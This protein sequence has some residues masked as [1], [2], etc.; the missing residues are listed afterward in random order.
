MRE[1]VQSLFRR[2][3]L[4]FRTVCSRPPHSTS[5]DVHSRS[6]A[7]TTTTNKTLAESEAKDEPAGGLDWLQSLAPPTATAA[8]PRPPPEQPGRPSGDTPGE[9]KEEDTDWLGAALKGDSSMVKPAVATSSGQ[10]A[11]QQDDDTGGDDWLAI[12]KSSGQAKPL[13]NPAARRSVAVPAPGGWM[14]S[15]KL[16]LS[17]EDGSDEDVAGKTSGGGGS[18]SSGGNPIPT[19]KKKKKEQLS[20]SASG[21]G[22]WLSSGALGVAVEDESDDDDDDDGGGPGGG[23]AGENGRGVAVTIE[24]QTEEDIESITKRGATEKAN[25]PKLPPW[26]KPYVPPPKPETEPDAAPGKASAPREEVEKEVI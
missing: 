11:D 19:K 15:G 7:A 20:V 6:P 26:A 10:K 13:H 16:G 12:A 5:S 22:G 14:S 18:G 2:S 17:T 4:T 25:V 8:A 24:T 23:D 3:P 21:P 9:A 1:L